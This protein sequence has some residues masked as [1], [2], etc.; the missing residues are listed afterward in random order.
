MAHTQ[1]PWRTGRAGAVV[2][3]FP[4]KEIGGSDD[5]EYYGGHLVCESVTKSN[6]ARIVACVNACAGIPIEKLTQVENSPAPIFDLL[7]QTAKQRDELLV[8][9]K[10]AREFI[11][12]GIEVGAIKM[13]DADTTDPALLTLPAI[14][15]AIAKVEA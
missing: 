10:S 6:A 14:E 9:L 8:A 5:I 7:L 1:E 15:A 11:V 3:N 2:A 12:N 13:P 4:I